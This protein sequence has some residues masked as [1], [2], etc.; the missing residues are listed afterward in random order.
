MYDLKSKGPGKV[1]FPLCYLNL[2]T[3]SGSKSLAG[4]LI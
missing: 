1:Q 3:V 4:I 2:R